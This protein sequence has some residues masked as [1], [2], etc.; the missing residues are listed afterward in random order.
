MMKIV[1]RLNLIRSNVTIN[2]PEIVQ[3]NSSKGRNH[4][5]VL[6]RRT[7]INREKSITEPF[8]L[9]FSKSKSH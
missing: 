2:S 4:H 8:K 5:T 7:N 6:K 3:G 1:D 9:P